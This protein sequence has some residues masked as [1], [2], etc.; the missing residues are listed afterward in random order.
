[1]RDELARVHDWIAQNPDT[2]VA[3]LLMLAVALLSGGAAAVEGGDLAVD[4]LSLSDVDTSDGGTGSGG[5][6]KP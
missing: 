4:T 3:G 6:S 1:M 2:I 5:P